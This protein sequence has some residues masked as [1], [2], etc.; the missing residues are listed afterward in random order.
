MTQA[1][2]KR[3]EEGDYDAALKDG[4]EDAKDEIGVL[5][6][7]MKSLA[8]QLKARIGELV[9]ERD[10]LQRLMTIRRDFV[11]NVSHELRTP[12]TSIQG[13]AETLVRKDPK[14][15]MR[16]QF[17]EVIH[18]QAQRIGALLEQLLAL[19]ELEAR[20]KGNLERERIELIAI[21]R[22]VSETVAGHAE[23]RKASVAID[24]PADLYVLADP[25]GVERAILNLVDNAVK[26]GKDGGK[27]VIS[28]HNGAGAADADKRRRSRSSRTTATGSKSNTCR[29]SSSAS[30]ASIPA[31]PAT[32]AAQASASRS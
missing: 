27:V 1:V 26:Y 13:Y 12:V 23:K 24:I 3:L 15:E 5:R 16:Q 31:A 30:T 4:S 25:E 22:H 18:R 2:A 32:T 14:P 29:A 7:A 17:L 10:R 19:S 20:G 6:R 8:A 9:E 11:A 21:A 28:A